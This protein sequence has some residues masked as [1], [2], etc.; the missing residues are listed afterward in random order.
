MSLPSPFST[1]PSGEPNTE[2]PSP[3][4]PSTAP[5]GLRAPSAINQD[6]PRVTEPA[7]SPYSSL[8][9]SFRAVM[10]STMIKYLATLSREA[11]AAGSPSLSPS[12]LDP[13]L[14]QMVSSRRSPNTYCLTDVALWYSYGTARCSGPCGSSL[15]VTSTHLLFFLVCTRFYFFYVCFC[16]SILLFLDYFSLYWSFFFSFLFFYTFINIFTHLVL[17]YVLAYYVYLF[18]YLFGIT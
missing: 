4:E 7:Y 1:V 15:L 8:L 10:L 3:G 17:T 14:H 6:S 13:R 9:S 18:I 12:L 2:A 11:L 16:F 5:L